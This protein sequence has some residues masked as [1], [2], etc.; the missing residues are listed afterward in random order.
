MIGP[1][2]T[3]HSSESDVL[4]PKLYQQINQYLIV[5]CSLRVFKLTSNTS[6]AKCCSLDSIWKGFLLTV[7]NSNICWIKL[8]LN[9]IN[10][11]LLDKHD[12]LH[13]YY[14]ELF[15]DVPV[16]DVCLSKKYFCIPESN[17]SQIMDFSRKQTVLYKHASNNS[18]NI[19]GFLMIC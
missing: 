4:E 12:L 14:L 1:E 19:H 10:T 3:P 6:N 2:C 8:D 5:H 11:R 17:H 9:Y 7:L 18:S 15:C 16:T 13:Q